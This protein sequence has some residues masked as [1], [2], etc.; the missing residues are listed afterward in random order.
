MSSCCMPK[1]DRGNQVGHEGDDIRFGLVGKACKLD[2]D[3]DMPCCVLDSMG[4]EGKTLKVRNHM[5]EEE[6]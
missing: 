1:K 2:E 4:Y 6:S 3:M 5:V